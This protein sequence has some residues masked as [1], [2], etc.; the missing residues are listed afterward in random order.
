M[1]CEAA[2]LIGEDV[3]LG[4]DVWLV[5]EDVRMMLEQFGRMLGCL[6]RM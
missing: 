3:M 1:G 4:G 2:W 6:G 5:E